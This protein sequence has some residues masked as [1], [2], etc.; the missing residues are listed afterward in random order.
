MSIAITLW[1]KPLGSVTEEDVAAAQGRPGCELHVRGGAM[2]QT[3]NLPLGVVLDTGVLIPQLEGLGFTGDGFARLLRD[4]AARNNLHL[5]PMPSGFRHAFTARCPPALHMLD[6]QWDGVAW[7]AQRELTPD[8]M[9]R[10]LTVP[11][12][13]ADT[14]LYLCM[15]S[16]CHAVL[17]RA[18]VPSKSGG[19][20]ADEP[21][22][23]KTVQ[24]IS[25]MNGLGYRWDAPAMNLDVGVGVGVRTAPL[26]ASMVSGTKAT[27]D[28][29]GPDARARDGLTL[30]KRRTS[31]MATHAAATEAVKDHLAR[32]P[33]STQRDRRRVRARVF[34]GPRAG[35]S[36]I[37]TTPTLALQWRDEIMDKGFGDVSICVADRDAAA[38]APGL[39]SY[40]VVIVT[41]AVLRQ[42]AKRF[43][44][45]T[46]PQPE[47]GPDRV[48]PLDVPVANAADLKP[49]HVVKVAPFGVLYV[50][51][52]GGALT[53]FSSAEAP[54]ATTLTTATLI[55]GTWACDAK[56]VSPVAAATTPDPDAPVPLMTTTWRRVICDESDRLVTMTQTLEAVKALQTSH[57]WCVSASPSAVD[58]AALGPVF[59][60]QLKLFFDDGVDLRAHIASWRARGFHD[61]LIALWMLRR[62][63]ADFRDALRLPGITWTTRP[64]ELTDDDGK[65]WVAASHTTAAALVRSGCP[66]GGLVSRLWRLTTVQPDVQRFVVL[67]QLGLPADASPPA[68]NIPT[69]CSV[70]LGTSGCS[71]AVTTTCAHVFCEDC[72][73][74]WMAASPDRECPIC[75]QSIASPASMTA[76]RDLGCPAGNMSKLRAVL[77]MFGDGTIA[78]GDGVVVSTRYPEAAEALTAALR[79]LLGDANVAWLHAKVSKAKRGTLLRDP[80]RVLVVNA[81]LYLFGLTLTWANHLVLVEEPPRRCLESQL[82]GRLHRIGQTK[83]ITVTRLVTK[84]TLEEWVGVASD[85][86]RV[87]RS[88][89]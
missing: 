3:A 5:E 35:G 64:V 60:E 87:L 17:S 8:S 46:S 65:R 82:V 84:D 51:G 42:Q 78:D 38:Q 31:D 18:V 74:G 36:L 86:G 14:P 33:W 29:Y 59:L 9:T 10:P 47:R 73:A 57:L 58:G 54:P 16:P 11:L 41:H 63:K 44:G 48:E 80:P 20:L 76:S 2:L 71:T 88:K 55:P 4:G 67:G 49:G 22:M 72:I 85:L 50:V 75:R 83:P 40:D 52:D 62:R 70:C 28:F 79:R 81:R 66:P 21:G 69:E 34:G 68:A 1:T 53:P 6:F 89:W 61:D 27:L 12:Y 24:L 43:W 56:L 26:P 19:F 15:H 37:V 7:M 25:L 30:V 77:S 45:S 23:G 39:A 32:H 13:V